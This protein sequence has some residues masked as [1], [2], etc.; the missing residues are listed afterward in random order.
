M[1]TAQIF[2]EIITIRLHLYTFLT[3][4]LNVTIKNYAIFYFFINVCI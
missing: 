2:H 1:L 3:P 4:D